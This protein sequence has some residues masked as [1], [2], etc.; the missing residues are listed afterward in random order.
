M[1][2]NRAKNIKQERLVAW[3]GRCKENMIG[4]KTN[5]ENMTIEKKVDFSR[6]QYHL[7]YTLNSVLVGKSKLEGADI[8]KVNL[9]RQLRERG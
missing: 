2:K 1:S 4:F 3:L 5:Y 7:L 8:N 9:E 6:K